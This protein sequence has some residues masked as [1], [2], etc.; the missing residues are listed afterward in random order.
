M[1]YLHAA[2]SLASLSTCHPALSHTVNS[3]H[4]ALL[5]LD[6]KGQAH[7][8]T[9]T[10]QDL[11]TCY[12]LRCPPV[13]LPHSGLCSVSSSHPDFPGPLLP[14][15][16][17]PPPLSFLC[18]IDDKLRDRLLNFSL[19]FFFCNLTLADKYVSCVYCVCGLT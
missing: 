2:V 8:H 7:P 1:S 6:K 12:A 13:S 15:V 4:T 3:R 10:P 9:H 14:P 11:C 18:I 16:P 19:I 17:P 5:A